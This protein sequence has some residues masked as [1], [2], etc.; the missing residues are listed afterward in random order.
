MSGIAGI[1]NLDGA[2]VDPD[3]LRSMAEASAFRGPDGIRYQIDGNIGFAYLA[4]HTT[5][6]SA[7]ERQPLVS[8]RTIEAG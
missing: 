8:R 4:L 2:P 1:V 6:E 3:L 5:P 7:R